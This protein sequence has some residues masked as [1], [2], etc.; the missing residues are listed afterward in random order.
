MP[1]VVNRHGGAAARLGSRLDGELHRA[2][3][4]AGLNVR[5]SFPESSEIAAAVARAQAESPLV[6]VGGGDG[7]LAAAA[8]VLANTPHVL[9]ILPLGTRNHLA[10]DLGL[11]CDLAEAAGVIAKGRPRHID[12]GCAGNQVFVNTCSIGLYASLVNERDR[13][14]LPKW[15][16][17][18]P[19]AWSVLRSAGAQRFRIEHGG[20]EHRIESPLLF[21]GNNR[22]S[23]AAGRLGQRKS[24]TSGRLSLAA[25]A[26]ASQVGLALFALRL[27]VGKADTQRDFTALDEVPS[28]VIYG[29][30]RRRV[31]LDGEVLRMQFPLHVGILPGALTVMA[32]LPA[33]P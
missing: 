11:P 5:L 31:A 25:V 13:H 14:G 19:A 27:L 10:R 3:A 12:L 26:P 24:L 29:H 21:I 22:H 20:A 17:T 16:A 6:V 8:G 23:L 33:P 2:F 18:L 30:H 7:T 9:G 4:A 32:P 1:V 15:L 28:L